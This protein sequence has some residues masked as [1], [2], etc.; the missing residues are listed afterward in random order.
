MLARPWAIMTQEEDE[1]NQNRQHPAR[2]IVVH[3]HISSAQTQMNHTGIQLNP[4][5]VKV[6]SANV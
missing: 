1:V 3:M 6:G 2:K 5:V 4:M